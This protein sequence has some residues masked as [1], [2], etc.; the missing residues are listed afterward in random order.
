MPASMR[1]SE[2]NENAGYVR[3]IGSGF[4]ALDMSH[5]GKTI[6]GRSV[7][8]HHMVEPE[9]VYR[10][11]VDTDYF[12]RGKTIPTDSIV[13]FTHAVDGR[14]PGE[15]LPNVQVA[16]PA[17]ADGGLNRSVLD[18]YKVFIPTG[19]NGHAISSMT[20]TPPLKSSVSVTHCISVMPLRGAS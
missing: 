12:G 10:A 18:G 11:F 1:L 13:A 15:L 5:I 4:T 19:D 17:F 14:L 2:A 7:C 8:R 6:M 3:V 16:A 9:Q 20:H